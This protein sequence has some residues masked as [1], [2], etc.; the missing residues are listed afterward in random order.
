MLAIFM[1]INTSTH[2]NVPKY[3]GSESP[4]GYST[5]VTPGMGVRPHYGTDL[6][7]IEFSVGSV[8]KYTD[9]LSQFLQEYQDNLSYGN[10]CSDT[11]KKEPC[12]F[13][14]FEYL[15]QLNCSKDSN[16]GYSSGAPCVLIKLNNVIS[17][18]FYDEISFYKLFFKLGHRMDSW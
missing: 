12:K 13:N 10:I 5:S 3:Y 4:L 15:D 16:Y 18:F 17:K 7:K 8:S 9:F 6:S 2:G 11:N 1:Q 14:I